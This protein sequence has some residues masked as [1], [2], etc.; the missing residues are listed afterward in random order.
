[1]NF[2]PETPGSTPNYWC[3][4][5]SQNWTVEER[6]QAAPLF[7]GD[8]GAYTARDSIYEE[9]F[10][11][12]N[13][14]AEFYEP[15][16]SDLYTVLDDGWDVPFGVHPDKNLASFG[17]VEPDRERF[18]SCRGSAAERLAMLNTLFRQRGWRGAGL[19]IAAHAAGE[20]NSRRFSEEELRQY[21]QT[22]LEWCAASG[23]D[24]WKVDWGVHSHD[25]EFRRMQTELGRRFA[26]ALNI[27]HC[28]P[29]GPLNGLSF[30][31]CAA[32]GSGRFA[33]G[34]QIPALLRELLS[35]SAITRVYDTV[36]PL[37]QATTLDRTAFCL[38]CRPVGLLNLE[39]EVYMA[40]ALG[41]T[42]GAMRAPDW[43]NLSCDRVVNCRKRG[44]EVVRAANWQRLAPAFPGTE[45]AI[46]NTVLYDEWFY[47]PETIWDGRCWG[48]TIRQGAP[49]AVARNTALPTASGPELPYLAASRHPGGA[50]AIAV[51]PRTGTAQGFHGPDCDV[52]ADPGDWVENIGLFGNFR[53]FAIRTGV[54]PKQI[55]LQDLAVRDNAQDVTERIHF[56]D[57]V[58]SLSGSLVRE[59]SLQ[60][61]PSEAQPGL[62][63]HLSIV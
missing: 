5:T 16:R 17:A 8:Q 56:Q 47:E 49:A 45:P 11:G 53:N 54:R 9:R 3:T 52:F 63:L 48:K 32:E 61:T 46:S 36:V 21:W 35:F 2:I 59:W 58:L 40:A 41:C 28:I 24:Y 12:S 26:P 50:Y 27:E 6:R 22:R 19:W 39:D 34:G 51:L 23:I 29:M 7:N 60:N 18:H 14:W 42:F 10:F 15:V 44:I 30:T 55:W 13:G 43:T 37:A 20:D 57:G 33:D 4:W 38:A 25:L 31:D 1:M 62:L